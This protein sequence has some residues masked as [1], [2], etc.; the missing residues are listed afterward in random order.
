VICGEGRVEEHIAVYELVP[1]DQI[2]G[3]LRHLRALLRQHEPSNERDR[4]IAERREIVVKY[5]ASN[6]PRSGS[7]PTLSTVMEVVD[8]FLLTV[9]AAHKLFGYD[10]DAIRHHDL[11]WNG[12][13]T[14]ILESYVFDR[15]TPLEFPAEFAPESAFHA[16][17]LLSHLIREW[18]TPVA[19]RALEVVGRPGPFYVHVGTEDSQGSSLPPGSMALVEPV[20]AAEA[21][22]PNPRL[23]YLL[24]FRNGYRCSRCVIAN[25]R[26]HLIASARSYVRAREFTFPGEVRVTGRVRMF[27]HALPQADYEGN[28]GLQATGR[29]ADLILP[30][31]HSSRHTLL[32]DE[33]RRFRRSK[34]RNDALR[35]FLESLL[36]SPLS[37][38]TERRYRHSGSSEPHVSTL[39]QLT[40]LHL[41]RYSDALWLRDPSP[42]DP[43]RYSLDTVLNAR[44]IHDLGTRVSTFRQ[45]LPEAAREF[46]ACDE[47]SQ[48]TEIYTA[49]VALAN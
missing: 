10:L 22:R 17:A 35:R 15:D 48:K 43:L 29:P 33:Y 46:A 5:L 25:G 13:R 30:W 36:R 1:R 3:A 9:G 34:D 20:S 14:H 26:L 39:I 28:N 2:I 41:A 6:L 38:R 31:E 49:S 19:I 18:Q 8:T 11:R 40:L 4:L 24:Q 12:D 21:A 23:I 32:L 42:D 47:L 45:P 44:T 16:D 27:A 37:K 7:H